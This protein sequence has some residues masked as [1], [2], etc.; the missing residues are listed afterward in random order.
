MNNYKILRHL[1]FSSILFTT[2]TCF[3]MG[4]QPSKSICFTIGRESEK[5]VT[6][7]GQEKYLMN[8]ILG[9]HFDYQHPFSITPIIRK[10]DDRFH[11][12]GDILD[13]QEHDYHD[14]YRKNY[15]YL[16]DH[17]QMPTRLSDGQVVKVSLLI[18]GTTDRE[19]CLHLNFKQGNRPAHAKRSLPITIPQNFKKIEKHQSYNK[20]DNQA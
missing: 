1:I 3:S 8:L 5:I 13:L 16:D 9:S 10:I 7:Q 12:I 20:T 2:S 14:I 4:Q 19:S 11:H 17:T 15:V 6:F 18:L